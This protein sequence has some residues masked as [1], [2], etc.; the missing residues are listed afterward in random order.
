MR[1]ILFGILLIF[2]LSVNAFAASSDNYHISAEV[3]DLGGGTAES[4]NYKILGKARSHMP[5]ETVSSNY[6]LQGGFVASV[7][8]GASIEGAPFI[9]SVTPNLWYNDSSISVEIIGANISTDSTVKLERSGIPSPING[10]NVSITSSTEMTCYFD[11]TNKSVGFWDVV[12]TNPGPK[13]GSLINGFQIK[14]PPIPGLVGK[15]FNEP[16]PFNPI[17]ESTQIKF[18]LSS[19]VT[20]RMYL[21]NQNGEIV[22]KKNINGVRGEN[23]ILWNGISD[24]NESVPTGVYLCRLVATVKGTAKE[25]GRIKIAVIRK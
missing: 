24:F 17:R 4:T 22:W 21:F 16:N 14:S 20:I 19:P 12:I 3:F 11:L 10:Y 25:L 1:K 23:I 6:V 18:T 13:T 8:S 7:Y 9:V 15:P 2:L 5:D